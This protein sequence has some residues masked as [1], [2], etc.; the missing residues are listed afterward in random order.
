MSNTETKTEALRLLARR[1]EGNADFMASALALYRKQ[2]R[3]DDRALAEQL[4][5][6]EDMLLRLALCKRPQ[7][8]SPQF[9]DQVRQMAQYV[10]IEAG[11]LANLLREI[12]SLE[13]F[14]Q[15]PE[16]RQAPLGSGLLAA[17]RDRDESRADESQG[18]DQVDDGK[19][20]VAG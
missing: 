6:S 7:S 13:Q 5:T 17:A 2:D 8:E 16:A 15:L 12:E 20:D 10:R 1:L 18:S 3:M 14:S 4:G 9:A 19:D 11:R